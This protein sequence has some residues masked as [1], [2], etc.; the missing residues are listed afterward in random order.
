MFVEVDGCIV[1]SSKLATEQVILIRRNVILD[2]ACN[3]ADAD[4]L[5]HGFTRNACRLA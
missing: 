4:V 2:L 1:S 3:S 5:C